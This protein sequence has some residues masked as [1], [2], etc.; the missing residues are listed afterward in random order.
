M[1]K[2]YYVPQF[3]VSKITDE[4][5]DL[6]IKDPN[7]PRHK[8]GFLDAILEHLDNINYI[9]PVR[10][11]IHNER[12]IQAGP[13]GVARLYALTHIRGYTHVPAIVST[14][15]YF[16]WFG[17]DV[18]EIIDKE[19]IR[20]YLRLEPVNYCIEPDGKVWWHNQN[21]NE[22]QLRETFKV[23]PETLERFLKCI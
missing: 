23:S 5:M 7:H 15:Q 12:D 13:T 21:P 19:Q 6:W 16:D 22:K 2:A 17:E 4:G 9:E 10:I 20:Y 11:V 14:T 1:Y 3:P 18:V 8:Y